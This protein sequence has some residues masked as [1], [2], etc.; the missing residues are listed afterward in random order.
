[1][2]DPAPGS[3]RLSLSLHLLRPV[4][5]YRGAAMKY[6]LV[7]FTMCAGLPLRTC[8]W[9][10]EGHRIIARLALA[11]LPTNFPAFA[12]TAATMERIAFLSGEADRWRNSTNLAARHAS[13]PDHYLDIDDLPLYGLTPQT[14]SRFRYDFV[15]QL[16][17]AR[18]KQPT[19]FRPLD[20]LKNTDHTRDLVGFLPWMINE[21]FAK[22]ESAFSYLKTFEEHGGT[23]DEIANAQQ[24]VIYFMGVLAHFPGD[25]SQPLHTTKH[26]NGWLG[27]NPQGFNT[28]QT[29]H[30]WIDGGFLRR[31]EIRFEELKPRMRRAE[32]IWG[33]RPPAND[34]FD[35]SMRFIVEQFQLVE[36]VYELDRD[37]KLSPGK[38]DMAEGREF[39]SRQLVKGG[40][41]L[42]DLW[43]SAWQN[44]PIDRY[45]RGELTRRSNAVAPR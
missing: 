36:R 11:S 2:I 10:Y 7:L 20:P 21:H 27:A 37:G 18:E 40:Q 39:I 1:M 14:V 24:N 19:K 29:I 44:A 35:E 17:L 31:A 32:S 16:K 13:A 15:A 43:F 9:D 3:T 26:Y 8:A 45:L 38:G 28:N 22:L 4:R 42:G 33:R 5:Q 25:A 12:R 6:L 41:F 30:A 34:V 23:R